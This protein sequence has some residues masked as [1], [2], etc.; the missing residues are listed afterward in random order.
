VVFFRAVD[1]SSSAAALNGENMETTIAENLITLTEKAA[2]QI[3]KLLADSEENKDKALRVYVEAGGCSGFQYGMAFDARQ[4]DDVAIEANG[5]GII[6]DAMSANYLKGATIDYSD[7]LQG[8]GF[9]V[10]NPNAQ[11]SCGCGKSFESCGS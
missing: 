11:R 4:P 5:V 8:T 3:K 10:I 7:G 9:R 6:V 2:A 1:R